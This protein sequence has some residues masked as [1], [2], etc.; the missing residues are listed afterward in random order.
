MTQESGS[1]AQSVACWRKKPVLNVLLIALFAEIGYA[2]LNLST[3]PVY[4]VKDRQ[5]G[6]AALGL[7]VVAYLFFEAGFKPV[8]GHIADRFGTKKLLVAGP[9]ISVFTSLLSIFLPHL[10]GAPI[11]TLEFIVLRALDGIAVAMLWPAAYA[12]MNAVVEDHER[13]RAMG[14]LNTCYMIGIA[15]AYPLGGIVNDLS[16]QRYAGIILAMILFVFAGFWSTRIQD[17]VKAKSHDEHSSGLKDFLDSLRQIPEYL[18]LSVITFMGI[19]FPLTIFKLFPVE[20]FGL[21]ESFIGMLILPGAAAMALLSGK[22]GALGERL[23][24]VRAVHYGLATCAAGMSLIALGMFLPFMRSPIF[25]ALG[26]LPVGIGFLIT[27]PAWMASVSDV[28]PE[29]RATNIGAVMTAQGVGAMIGAPIGA[30]MYEKLQPIGTSLNLGESF[31]R[32][33]PFAGCAACVVGGW[34]LSLKILHTPVKAEALPQESDAVI[35]VE[36]F[37]EMPTDATPVASGQEGRE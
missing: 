32:Y 22:M 16:G 31:G 9:I 11:E 21:S 26:G 27:I 28:N 24:R 29:K 6:T 20:E 13:Q 23:G 30:A 37:V 2:T 34:L 3:M 10:K 18:L 4:L 33:S 7:V 5:F 17:S 1:T 14:Y 12:Q 8:A 15:L 19:G 35:T 25:L 36:D